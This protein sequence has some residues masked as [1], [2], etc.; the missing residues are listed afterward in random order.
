MTNE[1]WWEHLNVCHN[2]VG[3]LMWNSWWEYTGHSMNDPWKNRI[4]Y[5][6]VRPYKRG[7]RHALYVPFILKGTRIYLRGRNDS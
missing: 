3:K 6:N 1:E 5:H 2:I 7:E 4:I